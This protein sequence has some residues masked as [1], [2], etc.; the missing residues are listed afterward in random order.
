MARCPSVATA[1]TP[2]L[3]SF[4]PEV[5]DKLKTY[6]YRL[7]D[8][9][10]GETFYVGK[11]V[12]NR[13]FAHVRAEIDTAEPGDKL[14]RIYDIRAAGFEPAHAIHRH[15]LD[16]KTAFEVEAALID[17]YPGLTNA[18]AGAGSNEYGAMHAQEIV[19]KYHAEPA[20][21][22]HR[23]VIISVNRSALETSLYEA[24]RYA[25]VLSPAKASRAEIVVAVRF[26]VIV[27]VFVATEW[28]P[29]VPEHFPGYEPVTGRHGFIGAEAPAAIRQQY[30]GKRLPDEFRKRGASNPI[31]YTY[32]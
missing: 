4:S 22:Q 18:V 8:P 26:G 3:Q 32:R 11:G 27:A 5:I 14:R 29:A 24:T 25:W 23:A 17:A 31:K 12:G 19:N 15:G 28:R 10:N 2:T 1:E 13:V 20:V 16:D 9:R 6:V 21:F 7:I 30:L